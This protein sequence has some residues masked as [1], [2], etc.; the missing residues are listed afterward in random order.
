MSAF[1]VLKM[2]C[3]V[4]VIRQVDFVPQSINEKITMEYTSAACVKTKGGLA[5]KST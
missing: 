1:N 4:L 3:L 5:V 2:S